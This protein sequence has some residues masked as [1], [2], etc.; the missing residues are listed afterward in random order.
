MREVIAAISQDDE[1]VVAALVEAL[2]QALQDSPGAS[3]ATLEERINAAFNEHRVA[4]QLTDG[5]MSP[6]DS[7][8]LHTQV[9]EPALRLLSTEGWDPVETAYQNAL[10]ELFQGRADDAITDATTALQEAL[11]LRGCQ[12]STL[13]QLARSAQSRGILA[14]YDRKLVEWAG[15]E[16]GQ[17]SD[18]HRGDSGA[19]REDAWLA[20]HVAGALILRTAGDTP[21]AV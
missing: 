9:V 18:A 2:H 14:P 16:R 6:F 19:S 1:P 4:W 3:S 10:R 17:R 5:F 7:K 12:G 8:E 11:C 13:A 15:A 20:V 21:R